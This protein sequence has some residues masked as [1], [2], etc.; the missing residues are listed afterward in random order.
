MKIGIYTD[1]CF[2]KVWGGVSRVTLELVSR[3]AKIDKENEYILYNT[4]EKSD[5]SFFNVSQPNF[6]SVAIPGSRKFRLAGWMFANMPPVEKWTG[7]LDVMHTTCH[8]APSTRSAF[9]ATIHDLYIITEQSR[10]FTANLKIGTSIAFKRAVRGKFIG[11]VSENTRQEV[12]H[13][14]KADPNKV[15]TIHNGVSDMFKPEQSSPGEAEAIKKKFGIRNE[16][17]IYVSVIRPGKNHIGLMRGYEKFRRE[18]PGADTEL[19]IAGKDG[20]APEFYQA[21]E[22]SEYKKDVHITGFIGDEDLPQLMRSAKGFVFPS[23]MEGFGL[24]VIEGLACGIPCAV[25]DIPTVRE[26]A[27]AAKVVFFNPN[28]DDEIAGG[29]T[30]L[31][32]GACSSS[33]DIAAGLARAAEFSWDRMAEKYRDLYLRAGR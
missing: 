7:K 4:Y 5:T 8:L 27:G 1:P 9:V 13:Y 3:L 18:N 28:S 6:R 17:F 26:V 15:V 20:D 30:A 24:P 23:L 2:Y 29:M 32:R 16:Y 21:L 12:I 22:K 10:M 33:E 31:Y 14:L 11:C 19:V 25:A